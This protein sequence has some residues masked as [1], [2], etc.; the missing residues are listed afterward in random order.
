MTRQTIDPWH[1]VRLIAERKLDHRD[2]RIVDAIVSGQPS[3]VRELARAL[4]I[5]P[6]SVCRRIAKL[7]RVLS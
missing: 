3:G 4:S 6:G 1:I 2:C 5:P 7:R